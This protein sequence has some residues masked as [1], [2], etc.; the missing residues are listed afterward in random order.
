MPNFPRAMA[1][2]AIAAF[3]RHAAAPAAVRWIW[4]APRAHEFRAGAAFRSRHRHRLFRAL[5]QRRGQ[6]RAA[7]ALRY[8][9]RTRASWCSTASAASPGWDSTRLPA[10]SIFRRAT[11]A[12][13]SPVQRLRS[14]RRRQSHRPPVQPAKVPRNRAPATQSR[15]PAGAQLALYLARCAHPAGGVDRRFQ[16]GRRELHHAST[17][18]GTSSGRASSLWR[19]RKLCLRDPRDASQV[20]AHLVGDDGMAPP[21]LG[22]GGN[23][24]RAG[25]VGRGGAPFRRGAASRA[26]ARAIA[27]GPH[28]GTLSGR[29]IPLPADRPGQPARRS[30]SR[31]R[32]TK[33][34]APPRTSRRHSIFSILPC[35]TLALRC[36]PAPMNSSSRPGSSWTPCPRAW[37]INCFMSALTDVPRTLRWG[38]RRRT[39]LAIATTTGCS[40]PRGRTRTHW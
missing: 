13:S 26:T 39:T 22:P 25:R 18:S 12:I 2:N 23:G 16:E 14:H 10:R 3:E 31:W 9:P 37:S 7:G 36:F 33:S 40:R 8:T 35:A 28:R 5:H 27:G 17:A 30:S 20:P 4:A 11:P 32:E 19:G 1:L 21:R 6:A 24:R 29:R 38:R 15:W 34:T